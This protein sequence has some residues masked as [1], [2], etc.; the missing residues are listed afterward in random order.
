[1]R[2]TM[3]EGQTGKKQSERLGYRAWLPDIKVELVIEEGLPDFAAAR[4]DVG[5]CLCDQLAKDMIRESDLIMADSRCPTAIRRRPPH[6]AKHQARPDDSHR[7]PAPP[8]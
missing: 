2:V 7:Q 8:R 5:V 4:Q 3:Q 1:M 6:E